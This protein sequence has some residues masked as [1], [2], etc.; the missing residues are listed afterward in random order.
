MKKTYQDVIA[1]FL[2]KQLCPLIEQA[3]SEELSQFSVKRKVS[4]AYIKNLLSTCGQSVSERVFKPGWLVGCLQDK[5]KELYADDQDSQLCE[6]LTL[7]WLDLVETPYFQAALFELCQE[8]CA[9]LVQKVDDELHQDMAQWQASTTHPGELVIQTA[10]CVSTLF[11]AN[12]E[13]NSFIT[14]LLQLQLLSGKEVSL[15]EKLAAQLS[16]FVYFGT[17]YDVAMLDL[18]NDP[19]TV[20][21]AGGSEDMD[22]LLQMLQGGRNSDG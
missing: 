7:E 22:D 18:M 2:S 11:K 12:N 15:V 1:P 10:K 4:S 16:K 13:S 21:A 5:C 8:S 6:E 17:L 14:E 9:A 19:A 20:Q 3:M